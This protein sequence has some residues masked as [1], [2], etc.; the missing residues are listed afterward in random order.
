[1]SSKRLP[2]LSLNFF[3]PV[4][5]RRC[6]SAGWRQGGHC[7]RGLRALCQKFETYNWPCFWLITD[8]LLKYWLEV[9]KSGRLVKDV[10]ACHEPADRMPSTPT[11]SQHEFC[12]R[13]VEPG[14]GRAQ[15]VRPLPI[16]LIAASLPRSCAFFLT[17][18]TICYQTLW[19]M[20]FAQSQYDRLTGGRQARAPTDFRCDGALRTSQPNGPCSVPTLCLIAQLIMHTH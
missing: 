6:L 7:D 9:R 16:M 5:C 12:V 2:L 11:V 8:C 13:N 1:M 17:N 20:V 14:I 4:A 3:L 19:R 10:E 15:D 18:P